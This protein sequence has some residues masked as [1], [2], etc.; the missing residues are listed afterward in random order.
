MRDGVILETQNLTL[1]GINNALNVNY[2]SFKIC[3]GD[4]VMI[5]GKNGCGKSTLFRY[6]SRDSDAYY[7]VS[8]GAKVYCG[9]LP[10]DKFIDGYT[11]GEDAALRRAV[12]CIGQEDLF[13]TGASAYYAL[14]APAAQAIKGDGRLT[15][16][17]KREKSEQADGLINEYFN[18]YLRDGFKCTERQ[19][20][21]GRVG[22]FSGGQQK[23]LHVLGGII[24]ARVCG[25]ELVTLD[26]PL[27]NL[28]GQNKAILN[29]I[30]SDLLGDKRAVMIIT[31]CQIFD[32]I[33]KVLSIVQ[34]PDGSG[35]AELKEC[36]VKANSGCLEDYRK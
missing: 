30:F 14:Y 31:H 20:R 17:Q 25:V 9:G 35:R 4:F 23:M 5:R 34:N 16:A 29:C 18:A 26:E 1:T 15:A 3:G 24:K 13:E 6:L 21:H 27:N 33:N 28:D 32:G 7:K 10:E 22:K 19:F 12:V 11:S 36:A 2:G 8:G